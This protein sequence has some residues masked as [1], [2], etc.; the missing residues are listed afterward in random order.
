V[1]YCAALWLCGEKQEYGTGNRVED[2]RALLIRL[3][4][5]SL[6]RRRANAN[7]QHG[8]LSIEE[9]MSKLLQDEFPR[10]EATLRY[11]E[12]EEFKD[13]STMLA[14]VM[15]SGFSEIQAELTNIHQSIG[16]GNQIAAMG[17]QLSQETQ[18]FLQQ[19]A[20]EERI[21]FMMDMQLRDSQHRESMAK[22]D[23]QKEVSKQLVAEQ[24][25]LR[26]ISDQR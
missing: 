2:S 20:N 16:L 11:L 15:R 4:Q 3:K 25:K 23:E 12:S 13:Y 21:R 18:R 19:Q 10:E 8:Y 9:R 26:R 1:W 14:R 5:I 6:Q 22:L 17:V 7:E 24:K